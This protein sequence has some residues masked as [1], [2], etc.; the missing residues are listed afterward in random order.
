[1]KRANQK[2]LIN[3]VTAHF[4]P[5]R[6]PKTPHVEPPV[7]PPPKPAITNATSEMPPTVPGLN[8][9]DETSAS[10][11]ADASPG[12]PTEPAPQGRSFRRHRSSGKILLL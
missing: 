2:P 11:V 12:S 9:S 5:Q 6:S 8:M 4:T 10:L 3:P 7:T 1:M